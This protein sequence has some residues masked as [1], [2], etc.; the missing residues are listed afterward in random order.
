MQMMQKNA[1]Q[2]D[3]S[4][5][6]QQQRSG[7]PGSAEN[8]PS[9]SKRQR[10]DGGGNGFNQQIPNGRGQQLPQQVGS[11]GPSN[12]IQAAHMQL[13]NGIESNSLTAEQFQNIPGNAQQARTLTQYQA[14]LAQQQKTQMPGALPNQGP[15]NQGSPSMMAG[16][17]DTGAIAG[18]YNAGE[19]GNGM[20][21]GQPGQGQPGGSGNHA[22]QDYQMQ[23]MLL[24]QQNK[25]R[26][27]M[28]RQEQDGMVQG[29]GRE[30]APGGMG[31]NGQPF[32]GTSPQGPRSVN[33][34]NPTDQMKRGTPHMNPGIPSPLPT[35]P[36]SRGSPSAMNFNMPGGQMDPNMAAPYFKMT[37][38]GMDPNMVGAMQANRMQPPPSSHPGGFQNALTPQQAAMVRQQANNANGQWPNGQMMPGPNQGAP[39][40]NIAG[41]GTPQQR[42]MPPPAPPAAGAAANGRAPSSPQQS[43]APPTPQQGNKAN[44]SKK[45]NES[46]ETKAKVI[47]Y[48]VK[49]SFFVEMLTLITADYKEGI[50]RKPQRWCYTIR[51]FGPRA[52]DPDACDADYSHPPQQ[53]QEW[54]AERSCA[55]PYE[56]STRCS[57]YEHQHQCSATR[58]FKRLHRW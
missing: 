25:K 32:P 9:P 39:Q 7:S 13:A 41:P 24:E 5:G 46:K 1:M 49:W 48:C 50:C 55:T 26:L 43:A 36:Q 56:W 28:A 8:A 57:T 51:G 34:P 27:M 18:Y 45:K 15:Q 53:L 4:G 6:D 52:C 2:R 17:Q 35:D 37:N 21:A 22:L 14:N 42:Q 47:H 54:S 38:G 19:M 3:P 44:P 33:S 11:S 23:L 58:S 29:G 30:G 31:P 20:R 40:Q 10:I 16:G 12:A